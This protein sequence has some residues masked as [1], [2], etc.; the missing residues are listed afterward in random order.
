MN[1]HTVVRPDSPFIQK[2]Q[3]AWAEKK[4]IEWIR[5]HEV[6]DFVYFPHKRHVA[7]G[8]S[9]ETCH[10]D[11]KTMDRVTQSASLTMGWCMECHRGQTTPRNVLTKFYPNDPHPQGKAV[12]AV[13]CSTCHH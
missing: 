9:C 13:N 10:G 1:C 12:A 5:V 3:K 6:P 7:A 2:L 11:V 4:P 8:V